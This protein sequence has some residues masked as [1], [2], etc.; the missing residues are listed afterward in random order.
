MNEI[1]GPNYTLAING[2][3]VRLAPE[4]VTIAEADHEL[5]PAKMIAILFDLI[6]AEYI[7]RVEAGKES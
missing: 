1:D 6:R 7:R 4:T 3:E 5:T 2:H